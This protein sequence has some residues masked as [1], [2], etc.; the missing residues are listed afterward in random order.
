MAS[1]L[2]IYDGLSL[3]YSLGMGGHVQRQLVYDLD[4]TVFRDP[5]D[6]LY[7][8]VSA[9]GVS[10]Q[11]AHPTVNGIYA[12]RFRAYPFIDRR[13]SVSRGAAFVEYGY[14]TPSFIPFGGVKIEL[15]GANTQYVLNR[16]PD[17]PQKGDSI[18]VFYNPDKDITPQIQLGYSNTQSNPIPSGVVKSDLKGLTKEGT[19]FDV[20]EIPMESNNAILVLTRTEF[21]FPMANY[22]LKNKLNSLP[23]LGFDPLT[24]CLRDVM[25]VNMVGAGTIIPSYN[26]VSYIFEIVDDPMK[27]LNVEFFKD[28]FTGGPVMGTNILDGTQNGYTI[29]NRWGTPVDFN[30]LKPPFDP[31]LLQLGASG[32]G[33]PSVQL[34]V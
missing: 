18:L 16:W 34:I 24:V 22:R 20:A 17:G 32:Q 6:L 33:A 3:D 15:K 4:Y 26:I 27:W 1:V 25:S 13:G 10:Y 14:S 23:F 19:L 12:A 7:A 31:K 28:R 2:K 5:A 29:V 30:Q 11:S 9:G 21:V 8:A